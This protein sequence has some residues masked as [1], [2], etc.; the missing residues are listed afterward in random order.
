M[1]SKSSRL[2]LFYSAL[3]DDTFQRLVPIIVTGMVA[4]PANQ[5]HPETNITK[6]FEGGDDYD[7]QNCYV[8]NIEGKTQA[9]IDIQPSKIVQIQILNRGDDFGKVGGILCIDR[10]D[11]FFY[12]G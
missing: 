2:I 12:N 5:D 7:F 11:L 3:P 6:V 10:T 8:S 9:R 4:D 1:K